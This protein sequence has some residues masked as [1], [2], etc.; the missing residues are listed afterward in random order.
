MSQRRAQRAFS[1]VRL[2]SRGETSGGHLALS[3]SP[4]FIFPAA[5]TAGYAAPPSLSLSRC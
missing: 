5:A 3:F 4:T 1:A 2:Q